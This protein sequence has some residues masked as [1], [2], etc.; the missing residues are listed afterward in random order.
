MFISIVFPIYNEATSI[1]E[2]YSLTSHVLREVGA[3]YEIIFVDDGSTDCSIEEIKKLQEIDASVTAIE[4]RRNFGQT[5]ALAAGIDYANGDVIITMDGDLQHDP[6][7][8]PRFLEKIEEGFDIVS[9][10]REVRKDNFVLRRLPSKMANLLMTLISGV[11]VKD[12]G[13]TYKAYKAE[14]VKDLELFG[15]L[16]RFI[17]I[18]GER[19]GA[20]IIEIPITV[21]PR[22]KGISKYGLSRT[23][24][25]F[26]DIIFLEF[27]SH[28]LTKPIRAFGKLALLFFSSGFFI[29]LV[30]MLLWLFGQIENVF[31]HGALLL[32][33]VFL[34][35]VGFQFFVAGVL[36]ELI[37]RIYH[38]TSGKKIYSTRNIHTK[39]IA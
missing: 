34:M 37:S 25:V 35:I 36:A 32:F 33:S 24:G 30:L 4:F 20:K 13:S 23:F 28:Y 1:K 18:L 5:A 31:E 19:I 6:R 9:G 17:P 10:W 12:F 22:E 29:S 26:Q 39:T 2:L 16:H 3:E 8:I 15:E 27:Y 14:L 11:K 21:L 7:E 38:H